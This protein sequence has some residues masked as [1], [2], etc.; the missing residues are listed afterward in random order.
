MPA[1]KTTLNPFDAAKTIYDALEPLDTQTRQRVLT[2]ALSLLGMTVP[3]APS[4]AI[5]S[6]GAAPAPAGYHPTAPVQ[7]PSH[8]SPPPVTVSLES[9]MKE[10]A[11]AT[12]AQRLAVFA[13][14]REKHEGLHRFA[15]R[16][17]EEY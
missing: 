13:Y 10:K 17:L 14:Y 5:A 16:D 8:Q 1:K 15:R 6:S 11:P 3:E 4:S 2:S 7:T 12:N 9:L